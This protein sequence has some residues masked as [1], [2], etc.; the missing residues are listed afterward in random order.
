MNLNSLFNIFCNVLKKTKH[1]H[2][3]WDIFRL[4]PVRIFSAWFHLWIIYFPS[5]ASIFST[6]F[7]SFVSLSYHLWE[8]EDSH[9]SVTPRYN[10]WEADWISQNRIFRK[11]QAWLN[12]WIDRPSISFSVKTAE[13][14]S[15]V[16][17]SH[18]NEEF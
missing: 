17:I 3:L 2:F 1:F 15:L 5:G 4:L 11:Q 10:M 16:R 14:P 13:L 12:L 18:L 7:F 9:S 8:S 6:G